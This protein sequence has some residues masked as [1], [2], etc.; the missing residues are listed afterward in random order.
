MSVYNHK[1]MLV[2]TGNDEA[3]I[4]ELIGDYIEEASFKIEA[5][6][7]AVSE[8]DT[9]SAAFISHSLKG[10]SGSVTAGDVQQAALQLE[11]AVK[12]V[13]FRSAATCLESIKKE[14]EKF[15]KALGR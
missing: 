11:S 6:R 9:A 3:F 5:L 7:Q 10:I 4:S 14:F 13:D 2:L 8:R 1:K 12:S 15:K